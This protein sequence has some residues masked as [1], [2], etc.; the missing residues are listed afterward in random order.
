MLKMLGSPRRNLKAM[1]H[2]IRKFLYVSDFVRLMRPCIFLMSALGFFPYETNLSSTK[3]AKMS[4]IGSVIKM[5]YITLLWPFMISKMQFTWK[6]SYF[7]IHI[8][9]IYT[10]GVVSL[11]AIFVSS[12][13]K[14]HL[15]RTVSTASRM[16]SREI[17]CS[18]AKWMFCINIVKLVMFTIGIF[19]VGDEL[20]MLVV[21][22][23]GGYIF[24]V[25]MLSITLF[26]NSLYVL[27][28]CFRKI[29]TSLEK[30]KN[31]LLTDEPHLLR[32]VYHS[33]K[34]PT[35][36]LELKMLRRQH[37]EFSRIIGAINETFGLE[38][39]VIVALTVTDITFNLY[40]FLAQNTDDGKIVNLWSLKIAYVVFNSLVLI[41]LAVVSE[42]VRDQVKN[43][44]TNIHRILVVTFDET[45]STEL[46]LFSMQ[47]L[48]QSCT[49]TAKG[50]VIDVTLLTKVVGIVTTYLLILI[51]LLLM[52]T[53]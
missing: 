12:R 29:N 30:L 35:L 4:F 52:K 38:I 33:Q 2:R 53:C 44:G 16:I 9:S 14:L 26:T 37:L 42:K 17:F 49:I 6:E 45:I 43:I 41:E 5:I 8:V 11:W 46:E 21:T 47:V 25:A 51:Q 28:L 23:V 32:R 10:F 48:Q 24:V 3:L 18:T 36:L 7:T 31:S 27:S 15:L 39:I 40:L 50:L 22:L 1:Y 34:N 19:E 13:S 20:W